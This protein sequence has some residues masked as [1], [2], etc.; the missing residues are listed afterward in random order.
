MELFRQLKSIF[1]TKIVTI[2]NKYKY[3]NS[4]YKL[5]EIY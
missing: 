5:F 2:H 1:E 3:R 4:I